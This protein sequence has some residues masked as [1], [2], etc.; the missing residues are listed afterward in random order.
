MKNFKSIKGKTITFN[1]Q[2][3]K[4]LFHNSETRMFVKAIKGTFISWITITDEITNQI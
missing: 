3:V 2:L 1:G 4:V